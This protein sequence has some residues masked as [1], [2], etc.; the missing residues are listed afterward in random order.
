MT[1][2]ILTRYSFLLCSICW[3][4]NSFA[5]DPFRDVTNKAF[6]KGEELTYRIHYGFIDAAYATIKIESDDKTIN[7]RTAMHVVGTGESKGAFN[8]F[9]KVRDRYETYIDEKSLCPLMFV[10]RVDEGGYKINQDMVFDQEYHV[11]NSNGKSYYNVPAYVQ[12]ML[13]SFYYARTLSYANEKPGKLDS[14]VC[15][16]DD[17][18]WSLKIKF[19][20]YET[21]K[22]DVGKIRCMVFEPIVQTGRIFKKSEDLKVWITDDSNHIPIRA[23]ANIIFG[24]IKMDLESYTGLITDF[25]KVK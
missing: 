4:F 22:S 1:A 19:V 2:P 21:L 5:Q 3:A 18:V 10:R 14:V 15:F 12:D 23:Q 7:G 13:S 24:S 11:V 16:V 9:F 6:Q 20:G 8:L 17:K 25:N